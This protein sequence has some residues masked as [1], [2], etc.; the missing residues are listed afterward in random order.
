MVGRFFAEHPHVVAGRIPLA[1]P[2][3][4]G[5][6]RFPAIDRGLRGVLARV[7]MERPR[8]GIRAGIL[9]AEDVRR[10][11]NLLNVIA[12]LRPPSVEPP[13]AALEFFRA[14]RHRDIRQ[15]WRGIPSVLRELPDVLRV[16][17]RRLLR[18]PRELELYVQAE[19]CP[20]PESRVVLSS[21][22]DARGMRR[23]E[24]QWRIGIPDKSQLARSARLIGAELQSVGLGT[25]ELEPWVT[26][27]GEAWVLE[28]FGGMHLMGT[29]RMSVSPEDGVVDPA[30]RVHG[31]DNL[32]IAGPS[33]FPSYG[34]A[35]PGLTIVA[36]TLFTAEHLHRALP[37]GAGDAVA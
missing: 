25:L 29:T 27:P 3:A 22:I 20:N 24:L 32:W 4:A 6:D 34:S 1:H 37:G 10:R 30:G 13:R 31:M 36:T 35:N 14:V 5:R 21:E 26:D 33:V 15:A 19:T 12:H 28:P 8:A 11:E 9:L 7:E 23:A 16:V 17:Y 18:R 2:S